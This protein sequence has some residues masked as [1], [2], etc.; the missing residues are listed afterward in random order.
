[1]EVKL[2]LK[3]SF[4]TSYVILRRIDKNKGLLWF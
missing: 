2:I 1:M 4:Y 3:L